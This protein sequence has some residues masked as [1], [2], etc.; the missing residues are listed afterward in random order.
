MTYRQLTYV[1]AV[2][3]ASLLPAQMLCAES[4]P[5]R[6]R[7]VTVMTRNLYVGADLTLVT[8]QPTPAN[9]EAMF[10][11]VEQTDF[12]ARA[13]TRPCWHFVACFCEVAPQGHRG[14]PLHLRN[15]IGTLQ[16]NR[17]GRTVLPRVQP[18]L[19]LSA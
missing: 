10:G 13:A 8:L 2:A 7:D 1:A 18:F 9:V 11:T 14:S 5:S 4:K 12:P 15:P 3:I 16:Y 19:G 6:H 17:G